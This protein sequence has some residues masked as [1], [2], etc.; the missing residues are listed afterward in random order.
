MYAD[1]VAR[2]TREA[3]EGRYGDKGSQ[4]TF[5]WLQEQNPQL[6][7]VV[8]QHLRLRMMERQRLTPRL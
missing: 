4:A 3:I 6:D 2:V 1:D 8:R 7:R 5:Q